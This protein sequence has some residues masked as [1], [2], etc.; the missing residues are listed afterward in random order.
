MYKEFS[1][2]SRFKTADVFWGGFRSY[3]LTTRPI[4][5]QF[6]INLLGTNGERCMC[7]V[8]FSTVHRSTSV[9]CC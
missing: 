8:F 3:G 2:L 5:K 9:S 1:F 6:G 7:K 4:F